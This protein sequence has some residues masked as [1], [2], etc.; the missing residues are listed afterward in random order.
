MIS[1][2]ELE[3]KNESENIYKKWPFQKT[4][5]LSKQ[6]KDKIRLNLNKS[7]FLIFSKLNWV[8]F[9]SSNIQN[10]FLTANKLHLNELVEHTKLCWQTSFKFQTLLVNIVGY[11]FVKKP[12]HCLYLYSMCFAFHKGKFNFLKRKFNFYE[13]NFFIIS[14]FLPKTL[15]YSKSE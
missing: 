3:K 10:K 1:N 6:N 12:F 7:K 15:A 8:Y 2:N 5:S 11:L 9:F 4:I 14:T 13:R